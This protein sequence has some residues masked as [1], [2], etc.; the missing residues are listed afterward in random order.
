MGTIM[1]YKKIPREVMEK[2]AVTLKADLT[3]WFAANPKRRVCNA[4]VWYGRAVK[5]RKNTIS[6]DVD[7]A[8]ELCLN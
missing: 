1:V 8:V 7:A 4:Q 6:A 5:I 2:E 3:K